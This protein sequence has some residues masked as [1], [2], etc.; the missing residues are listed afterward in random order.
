MHIR[1]AG[2]YR[3]CACLRL[4]LQWGKFL[5][6]GLA[7]ISLLVYIFLFLAAAGLLSQT[8]L[9]FLP[10]LSS[11]FFTCWN[12][13]SFSL[14]SPTQTAQETLWLHQFTSRFVV[15]WA[16]V[17][18]TMQQRLS[19]AATNITDFNH[20]IKQEVDN[21]LSDH[22]EEAILHRIKAH[23]CWDCSLVRDIWSEIRL[24]SPDAITRIKTNGWRR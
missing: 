16:P 21:F 1:W 17:T 24:F 18:L 22:K 11:A 3:P 12:D 7:W 13:F 14:I 20:T 10:L 2:H 15:N 9:I 23:L 19:E 6:V 8:G 4:A 5:I